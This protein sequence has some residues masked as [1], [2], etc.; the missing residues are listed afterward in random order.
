MLVDNADLEKIDSPVYLDQKESV[1]LSEY[2]PQS[3]EVIARR[4][5]VVWSKILSI[6]VV[7]PA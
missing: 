1:R 7:N 3:S 2:A 5:A 6:I 4:R